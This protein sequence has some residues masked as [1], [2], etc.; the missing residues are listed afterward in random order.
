MRGW[1][2][3]LWSSGSHTQLCLMIFEVD[4]QEAVEMLST[5]LLHELAS[6]L[7]FLLLLSTSR[8]S[9]AQPIICRSNWFDAAFPS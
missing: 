3:E 9:I 6:Q 1:D 2:S 8:Q 5:S 7:S 4:R